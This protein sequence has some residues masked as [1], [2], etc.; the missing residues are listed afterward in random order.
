MCKSHAAKV[1]FLVN[2]AEYDASTPDVRRAAERIVAGAKTSAEQVARLLARVQRVTFTKEKEETFSPTM[3]TL[4]VGVGDCDD[5][6]RALIALL[7]S[8]GFEAGA[9]TLP[10]SSTG[11][12]PIHVAAVVKLGGRWQWLEATIAARVGESPT[13]AARRLGIKTRPDLA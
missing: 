2:L 11:K 13:A 10:L 6:A 3:W 9:E 1:K 7:R 4:D 8:L 12:P 5:T